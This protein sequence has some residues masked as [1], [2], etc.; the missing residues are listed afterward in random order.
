MRK[1]KYWAVVFQNKRGTKW[2]RLASPL[3]IGMNH[4]DRV[5]FEGE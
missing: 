4:F 3:K 2:K 5:L 1:M